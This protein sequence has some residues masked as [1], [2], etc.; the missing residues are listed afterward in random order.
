VGVLVLLLLVAGLV[1]ACAAYL[2]GA[3]AYIR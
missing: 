1:G 2:A 3:S